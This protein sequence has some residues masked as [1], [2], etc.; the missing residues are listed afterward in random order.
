[1]KWTARGFVLALGIAR[2]ERPRRFLA[3][4]GLEDIGDMEGLLAGTGVGSRI[5][6]T[7]DGGD[8]IGR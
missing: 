2:L 6:G 7:R 3:Q 5:V 4:I 8:G 1:M